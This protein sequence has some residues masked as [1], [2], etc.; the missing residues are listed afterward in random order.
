M[1]TTLSSTVFE[2]FRMAGLA[3]V[4][5]AAGYIISE[6]ALIRVVRNLLARF[7]NGTWVDFISGLVRLSLFLLTGKIIIEMTGTA[8]ALVVIV[9]AVTGAFAIGSER[10]ASDIVSG[11]KLMF[12]RYYDVD[13]YVTLG[14]YFGKV[15]EINMSATSLLTIDKDKIIIPNSEAVNGTLINHSRVSGYRIKIRIPV[16]GIHDRVVV[17]RVLEETASQFEGRLDGDSYRPVVI[18]D[19]IGADTNFYEVWTYVAKWPDTVYKASDLRLKLVQALE[20]KGITVGLAPVYALN[21]GT[22]V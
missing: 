18:F 5:A 3:V 8:G 1:E 21:P 9:T 13:E 10:L 6:L 14:N 12:L 7:M 2:F 17:L 11:V 19:G 15:I 4:I 16:R 22:K 20:A